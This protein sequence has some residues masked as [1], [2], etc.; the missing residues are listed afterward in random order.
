MWLDRRGPPLLPN[1]EWDFVLAPRFGA[2]VAA[3][4]SRSVAADA[5]VE[6]AVVEG[7]AVELALSVADTVQVAV[8]YV[9]DVTQ[10]TGQAVALAALAS[11]EAYADYY[12]DT[13]AVLQVSLV[14]QEALM[15][16]CSLDAAETVI[17]AKREIFEA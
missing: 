16:W 2:A 7:V 10:H 15:N 6:G 11:S 9:V 17:G 5:V 14:L 12:S 3:A 1:L 8:Q 13:W 4:G